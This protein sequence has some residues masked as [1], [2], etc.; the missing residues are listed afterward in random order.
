MSPQRGQG[1]CLPGVHNSLVSEK[2]TFPYCYP[3]HA[4]YLVSL[5]KS[6]RNADQQKLLEL[7]K[8]SG[9]VVF[10]SVYL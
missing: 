3:L 4:P 1:P 8:A 10:D 5:H 9:K 2:I 7:G 6:Y